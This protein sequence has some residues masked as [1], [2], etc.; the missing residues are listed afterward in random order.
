MISSTNNLMSRAGP[1]FVTLASGKST[2]YYCA[3]SSADAA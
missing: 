1:I 3:D 2:A